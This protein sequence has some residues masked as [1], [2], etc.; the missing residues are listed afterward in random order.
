MQESN[1][2]TNRTT[3]LGVYTILVTQDLVGSSLIDQLY[4]PW[5]DTHT[6]GML[7]VSVLP[8]KKLKVFFY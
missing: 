5:R 4:K 8:K 6:D 1:I 3:A 7:D 2:L